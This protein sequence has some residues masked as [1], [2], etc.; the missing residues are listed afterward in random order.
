MRSKRKAPEQR[1]GGGERDRD[2]EKE[3]KRDRQ[4]GRGEERMVG[5]VS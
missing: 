4:G 2:G 3:S 5:A 1:E